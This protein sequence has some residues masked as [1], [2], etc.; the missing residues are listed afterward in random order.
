MNELQQNLFDQ[1]K[2]LKGFILRGLF[3][4]V[5][6]VDEKDLDEE[7]SK[8]RR[9]LIS[10]LS[11]SSFKQKIPH[12]IVECTSFD[13]IRFIFCED[14]HEQ[15]SLS[16]AVNGLREE[17]KELVWDIEFGLAVEA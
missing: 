15:P 17:F 10:T 7:Y 16:E 6:S 11:S 2:A 14:N 9:E 8:L 13:E 5:G 3:E 4:N 12:F 1:V